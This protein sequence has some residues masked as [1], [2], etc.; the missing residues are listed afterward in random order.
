MPTLAQVHQ[1]KARALPPPLKNPRGDAHTPGSPPC[2]PRWRTPPFCP[3]TA[4][5]DAVRSRTTARREPSH[6]PPPRRPAPATRD[7]PAP[8]RRSTGQRTPPSSGQGR[9]RSRRRKCTCA[10]WAFAAA[11]ASIPA[12]KSMA[13]GPRADPGEEAGILPSAAS[14]IQDGPE[15]HLPQRLADHA[16]VQV[17]GQVAVVV[18]KSAQRS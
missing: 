3:D 9:L 2:P 6:T 4:G 10:G 16:P 15:A 5:R 11:C 1:P 12:D 17:A 7:A 18:I 8:D 14:A 13:H